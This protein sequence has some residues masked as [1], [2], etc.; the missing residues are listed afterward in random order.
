MI[1]RKFIFCFGIKRNPSWYSS[2]IRFAEESTMLILDIISSSI[3]VALKKLAI[4]MIEALRK[5]NDQVK[6]EI[7]IHCKVFFTFY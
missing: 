6:S 2:S 4:I 1:I 5:I 7:C 3:L